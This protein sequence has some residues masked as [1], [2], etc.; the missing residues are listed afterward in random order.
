MQ[1]GVIINLLFL[2]IVASLLCF[3]MW[4]ASV[5]ELG[6]V[7]TTNYI[8]MVPLVTLLTSAIAIDEVITVIALIGSVFILSGVYVAEKGFKIS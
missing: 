3:I 8:Y 6:V 4:N 1:P 2:S 7:R 5:K